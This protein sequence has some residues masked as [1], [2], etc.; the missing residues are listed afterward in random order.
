MRVNT[1]KSRR[2]LAAC[3]AACLGGLAGFAPLAAS[4][5]GRLFNTS[6]IGSYMAGNEAFNR[7]DTANAADYLGRAVLAAPGDPVI[8]SRAFLS[9]LMDGRI[10]DATPLANMVLEIEPQDELARLT[11]ATNALRER[12]Y[13]AAI[14]YLEP[15]SSGSIVGITGRVVSAWAHLGLGDAEGAEAIF[16]ELDDSGFGEFLTIHRALLSDLAGEHEE[17][18]A[19]AAMAYEIEPFAPRIVETY[20]RALANAG[21]FDEARQVIE[22]FNRIALRNPLIDGLAAIVAAEERPGL[23]AETVQQGAGELLQSLGSALATDGTRELG[24]VL[25]RLA[26]NLAPENALSALALADVFAE[27]GQY[28]TASRVL[29]GVPGDAPLFVSAQIRLAGNYDYLGQTDEAIVRLAELAEQ[30]PDNIEVLGRLGD[31]LR[32]NQRWEEAVEVYDRLVEQVDPE[33]PGNWRYFYVR[34]IALERSGA[35]DRAEAD[36]LHA[37]DLNPRH[38]HVLNYLGYTWVDRGENLDR[39]LEMIEQAIALAPTD[40]YIIDSLGWGY[41][42]LGHFEEAVGVLECAVNLMPDDAEL[43]DH[44]GDAYW[45]VGRRNEAVFQ[46]RIAIS[47]DELG[48]VTERAGEKLENGLQTIVPAA[49]ALESVMGKEDLCR[50]NMLQ[51]R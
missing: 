1:R 35:W 10:F 26:H 34:G 14:T 46:W 42:R 16:A 44:L 22:D 11:L 45:Q 7:L 15:M 25:L 39:G 51:L 19:F 40:G 12:R 30:E 8:L 32:V 49:A 9:Y 48:D 31:I 5:Q 38:P 20:G 2:V 6:A 17:A 43:N 41:Y 27:M 23:S 28:N 29:A 37:L 21:R 47:V 50:P 4:A 24:I 13:A 18:L 3:L 33:I 36:F